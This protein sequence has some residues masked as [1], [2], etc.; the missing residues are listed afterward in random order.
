MKSRNQSNKNIQEK[1]ISEKLSQ[2]E[3]RNETGQLTAIAFWMA[4]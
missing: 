1:G 4:F 3:K 2:L